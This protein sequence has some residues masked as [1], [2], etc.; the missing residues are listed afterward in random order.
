MAGWVD[1]EE[2]RMLDHWTGKTAYTPPTWYLGVSLTQPT[3]A[4]GNVTEP[5]NGGYQ[6]K[7]L[8]AASWT[9]ATTGNPSSTSYGAVLTLPQATGGWGTVGW[10]VFYSVAT[11][12]TGGVLEWATMAA[13]KAIQTNDQLQFAANSIKVYLGDPT[14]TYA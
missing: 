4:G 6:R 5:T 12:G 13:Q 14:D 8:A 9:P 7:V 10:Q 1:A 2:G 3:D 11:P